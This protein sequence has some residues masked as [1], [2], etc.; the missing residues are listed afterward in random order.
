MAKKRRKFKTTKAVLRN[1]L[2]YFERKPENWTNSILREPTKDATEGVAYC[3][4][5]GCRRF[6]EGKKVGD[7]AIR[8]LA[9]ALGMSNAQTAYIKVVERYVYM[10]NDAPGG[11]QK[12]IAGLRKA[13]A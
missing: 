3:A 7:T 5:G 11:K 10:K 1:T 12:I 13:V 8:Y 4:L 9:K 6:A 2:K